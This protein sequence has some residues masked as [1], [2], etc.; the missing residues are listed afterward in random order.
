MSSRL[1]S[2]K[3]ANALL[4]FPASKQTFE[5]GTSVQ[6]VLISDVSN[7]LTTKLTDQM[8][9]LSVGHEHTQQGSATQIVNASQESMVQVAILT[10]SDTVS[11][12][13]GPDRRYYMLSDFLY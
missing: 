4:E 3:A 9:F 2:M 12:G 13:S 1:L 6:A 8:A 10:V 11:S 7:I 5:A